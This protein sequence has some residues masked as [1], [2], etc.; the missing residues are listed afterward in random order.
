MID[1][2]FWQMLKSNA[3]SQTKTRSTHE[4]PVSPN[5]GMIHIGGSWKILH[6]TLD[7]IFNH[8]QK[9]EKQPGS[10]E[11]IFPTARTNSAFEPD[12]FGCL[13]SILKFEI[14][15]QC[16]HYFEKLFCSLMDLIV[17]KWFFD[18]RFSKSSFLQKQL[19][20]VHFLL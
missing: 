11:L 13:Q 4:S 5:N 15:K 2:C 6:P 18:I 16:N 7:R 8:K 19:L 12:I 1:S 20:F 9:Q 3:D 10:K 14:L 17:R